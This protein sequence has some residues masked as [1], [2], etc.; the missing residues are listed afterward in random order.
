MDQLINNSITD[1]ATTHSYLNHYERLFQHMKDTALHVLEIGIAQGGSIKLWTDYFSKATIYA[2]DIIEPPSWLKSYNKER[3]NL[4]IDNAYDENF[5]R[6][7]F[8]DKGT[9][10]DIIID[11]GP[12]TKESMLFVA[13]YYSRLLTENGI[14]IIEDI[15]LAVRGINNNG[16]N[17]KKNWIKDI[18]NEFPLDL[19]NKVH[20]L[21]LRN[22]R[23]RFDNALIVMQK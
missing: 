19:Q 12:H 21:D 10:F 4:Y 6:N 14:L 17:F 7:N 15:P 20:L 22:E 13:K 1:K 3:I 11:D 23:A 2:I 8:I 18:R 5:I 16:P 9:K